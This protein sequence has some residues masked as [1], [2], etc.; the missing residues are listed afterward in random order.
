MER[1]GEYI[2]AFAELIGK[3][4]LPVFK[5]VKRA[6]TGIQALVPDARKAFAAHRMRQAFTRP[7]TRAAAPRLR[8]ESMLAEDNVKGAEVL[9]RE[10]ERV[11]EFAVAHVPDQEVQRVSQSGEIDGVV[12]G[13]VGTEDALLLHVRDNARRVIKLIV[14]DMALAKRL[15]THFHAETLRL[16]VRGTWARGT[17]GW[18]PERCVV[19]GFEELSD[20]PLLE[21]LDQMQRAEGNGWAAADDPIELWR[22][23]RGIH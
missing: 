1:I 6:S 20:M 22:S 21:I 2:R 7:E 8:I 10:G 17:D 12:V 11:F 5:G 18:L 13:L 14:N 9:N 4:N 23:L 19:D 15:L 3:E 16:R